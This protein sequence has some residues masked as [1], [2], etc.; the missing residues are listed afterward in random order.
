[1]LTLTVLPRP[2]VVHEFFRPWAKLTS[3]FQH[4]VVGLEKQLQFRACTLFDVTIT[5][6]FDIPLLDA[7]TVRLHP[8]ET[9]RQN[10]S[11]PTVTFLTSSEMSIEFMA[12]NTN[13]TPRGFV[14][15][16][17]TSFTSCQ[18]SLSHV[19]VIPWVPC[20]SRHCSLSISYDPQTQHL[21]K[22]HIIATPKH[23][24]GSPNINKN[25][26]SAMLN[27]SW[28]IIQTPLYG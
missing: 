21:F 2:S 8:L 17:T 25:I 12:R 10:V 19:V 1:M 28:S 14:L 20:Y 22:H 5:F 6:H 4:F 9:S 23:D 15:S 24:C 7:V 3:S 27:V 26:G 18:H 16:S 11:W 13:L